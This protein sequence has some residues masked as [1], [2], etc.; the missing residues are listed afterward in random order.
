MGGGGAD[1]GGGG[2]ACR[3][4]GSVVADVWEVVAGVLVVFD[5]CARC[6]VGRLR[7]RYAEPGCSASSA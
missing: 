4:V 3:V 6:T 2:G 1:G 5:V 7:G